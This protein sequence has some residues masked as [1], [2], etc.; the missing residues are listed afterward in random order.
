M[1]SFSQKDKYIFIGFITTTLLTLWVISPMGKLFLPIKSDTLEN[2][3]SFKLPREYIIKHAKESDKVN[4]YHLEKQ[5]PTPHIYS[6]LIFNK[7]QF[8]PDTAIDPT[9]STD[10]IKNFWRNTKLKD[11]KLSP[12]EQKS[13]K[14]K[15]IKICYFEAIW[16]SLNHDTPKEGHYSLFKKNDKYILATSLSSKYS[17]NKSSLINLIT[18]ILK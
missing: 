3:L 10:S 14:G 6:L 17:Y 12:C 8:N 2:Q 13:I 5:K 7:A 4:I 18:R 9:N 15:T 1:A 16:P 11:F